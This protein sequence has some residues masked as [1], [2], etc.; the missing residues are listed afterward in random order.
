MS[1]SNLS[2]TERIDLELRRLL[3]QPLNRIL[4]SY[5]ANFTSFV[6]GSHYSSDQLMNR[7]K[8]RFHLS[9]T[10]RDERII[11]PN[12]SLECYIYELLK[13]TKVPISTLLGALIYIGR[14]GPIQS[15]DCC[16]FTMIHRIFLACL[17][18]SAKYLNDI[19]P[20]NRHWAHYSGLSLK[21]RLFGFSI[22]DINS[23]EILVLH[24]LNWNLQITHEDLHTVARPFLPL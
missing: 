1:F 4:I 2:R 23:M 19:S 8:C 14:L 12:H 13:L 16:V 9:G 18:L 3:H 20:L 7:G 24:G 5:V 6:V 17:I 22:K 10:S 21:Q 11:S 15:L